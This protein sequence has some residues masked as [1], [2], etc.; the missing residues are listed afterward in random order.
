[1]NKRLFILFWL[2]LP[3]FSLSGQM[4]T[5]DPALPTLGKLIKIYYD[6]SKDAGDLHNFTGDLYVH[7]GVTINGVNW[8][9]VIGT[10]AVNSTQPKLTYLGNYIYELDIT[11]DIKTFYSI[12][13]S[14]VATRICLVFRNSS[15]SLQTRPDIFIDIF[16]S[17]L[18]ATFTLPEKSSLIAELNEIIP[19][20]AA[21]AGADSITLYVNNKYLI[22]GTGPDQVTYSFTADQYGEFWVKAVAWDKPSFSADSFF[23]YV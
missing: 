3:V 8:Q 21:A 5:T 13:A 6:T 22:S 12:S 18:N 19:V 14:S 4:V 23:V 1:M 7:T 10:W 9:N 17:G 20:K 16:E 11:P 2:L 15:G